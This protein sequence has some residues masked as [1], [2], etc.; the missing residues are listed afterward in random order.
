MNGYKTRKLLSLPVML[1]LGFR[2]DTLLVPLS[3]F[4]KAVIPGMRNV[5]EFLDSCHVQ[6][7][8]DAL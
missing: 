2:V 1:T 4:P 6:A 7:E 8:F 3:R 5:P